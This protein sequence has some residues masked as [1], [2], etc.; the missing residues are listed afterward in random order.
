MLLSAHQPA[1]LPWLG[2]FEKIA[3]SDV[4]VFLDTVQF[5]KNSFINRNKIKT[6]QGPQWLT[7][8]VMTKGHIKTTLRDT[9]IDNTQPWSTKHLKTIKLQYSKASCFKEC[10]PK[11]ETLY[12]TPESNLAE[13]CWRQLQFWLAELEIK[14]K[15]Y[16]SSDLS[17][18]SKKSD[19]V[20]D[21]C[22]YFGAKHYLS[23]ALGKNYLNEESFLTAGIEIEY[24]NFQHP[25]YPQ[26]WH[27]FEPQM[28]I[29]DVWMNC[30]AGTRNILNGKNH[31]I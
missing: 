20:L 15:V 7:I 23:G 16:R 4:F 8:P 19:L 31:G 1:Y 12:L 6:Q 9:L 3:R 21:F 27:I 5:E 29:V 11:L 30:G 26:L 2:Y 13:L 17:V 25:V 18:A 10:F 24:Q 14:T 28:G 22:K